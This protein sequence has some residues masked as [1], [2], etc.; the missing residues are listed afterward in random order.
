MI[1]IQEKNE[2]SGTGGYIYGM[3]TVDEPKELN[4]GECQ[5]LENTLPGRVLKPRCGIVD[6]FTDNTAIGRGSSYTEYTPHAVLMTNPDGEDY[7]IAWVR[8]LINTDTF[9]IE[10]IKVSDGSR[11]ALMT[12]KFSSVD[13]VCSM[14]KLYSSVYCAFS[15]SIVENYT[16]RYL[17]NNVI[18]YWDESLSSWN[19]RSWGINFTPVVDAI[20]CVDTGGEVRLD[21]RSGASA[22]ILGGFIYLT[23]GVGAS[24]RKIDSLK[25]YNLTN[26]DI[27]TVESIEYLLDENGDPF[28]DEIVVPAEWSGRDGHRLI[29]FQNRIWMMGGESDSGLMNDLWYTEDGATWYRHITNCDWIARKDFA[30]AVFNNKLFLFGGNDSVG[31]NDEIW[32]FDGNVWTEEISATGFSA[33]HSHDVVVYDNK[34]W[35]AMGNAKTDVINSV[36]GITWNSVDADIGLG[37]RENFGFITHDNKMWIVG[38]Y[39]GSN[40]LK[41]V[42]SST[43]GTTWVNATSTAAW[44]ERAGHITFSYAGKMYVL[45]GYDGTNFLSDIWYSEDGATWN[46]ALTGLTK[47]KYYGYA[48]TLVRRVDSLSYLT[49]M[50]EYNY[51]PWESYG[52][53]IV[54]SVN[55]KL[56]S[57]TVSLINTALTGSETLFEDELSVGDRIRIDG[58]YNYY[59]VTEITDDENAVVE[60]DASDSYADVNFALLPADGDSITTGNYNAGIDESPEDV[61]VRQIVQCASSTDYGRSMIPLPSITNAVAQGVTHLRIFRTIGADTS[62]VASGLTFLYLVDISLSSRTYDSDNY[63]RDELSDDIQQTETHSIETNGYSV[64]PFG[65][66]LTWDQERMWMSTG[67]GFW[68][69]SVGASQDVEYPQKFAS[70]FNGSTQRIVCD[71]EDGQDDTGSILFDGDLYLFKNRKIHILDT[72]NPLYVPRPVSE[73]IGC[74]FP[75]TINSVDHPQFGKG[76]TFVSGSGPA[77]LRAGGSVSLFSRFKLKELWPDGYLHIDLNTNVERSTSWKEAVSS[78]W[79]KNAWRIVVP[80]QTIPTIYSFYVDPD[81]EISGS[82]VD[83]VAQN[84]LEIVNDPAVII[85]KNDSIAYS[86]SSKTNIYRLSQFL[87]SGVF[88]DTISGVNFP[89]HQKSKSRMRGFNRDCSIMG[90]LSDVVLHL[91]MKENTGLSVVAYCD[92]NRFNATMVYSESVDTNL[93]ETGYNDIRTMINGILKEGAYGRG[94]SILVDKIVPESGDFSFTG[95]DMN[96]QPQEEFQSEFYSTFSERQKGWE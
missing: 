80:G 46:L 25:T 26:W 79:F 3:N 66:F 96:I 6:L 22:A 52:G 86:L 94:F 60:N 93:E 5:L 84:L 42:Y 89:Y 1:T 74:D 47:N 20:S 59:T 4:Q 71:P 77:I 70:L 64:A 15:H 31:A 37:A 2:E 12:A 67:K 45:C 57:G 9:T 78:F 61:S 41:S 11:S 44:T 73:G 90:E 56:L 17:L 8:E 65:K 13:T 24:G 53:R 29:S 19:V 33:R 50:T 21:A 38:G 43:D 83:T 39:N 72:A 76:I 62:V 92:K 34:L 36:D 7:V 28:I 18:I 49:S 54:T 32:S 69:F 23:M 27:K 85:V 75:N 81:D 58:T 40:Y 51:E 91:E 10:T 87:K 95:V 63:Y 82:F 55:E 48:F 68:L 88:S 16:N 35:I 30:V 14:K